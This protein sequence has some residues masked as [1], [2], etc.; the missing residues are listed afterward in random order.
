MV[1]PVLF[2]IGFGGCCGGAGGGGGGRVLF[3]EGERELF[4]VEGEV[5]VVGVGLGA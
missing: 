2:L 4:Q 5:F 3:L 1:V